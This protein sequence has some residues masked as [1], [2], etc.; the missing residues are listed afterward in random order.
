MS[1]RK[2]VYKKTSAYYQTGTYGK[3]L[4]VMTQRSITPYGDDIEITI[5]PAY[6]YRPDLLA[7]DLYGDAALWWVFAMRNPNVLKNPIG[8]FFAGQIILLPKIS[9]LKTDLGL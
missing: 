4:D 2:T 8:D 3:F 7:Y 9:T 1:V 5:T 6:E